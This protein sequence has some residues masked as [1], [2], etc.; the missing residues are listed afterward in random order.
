P[1]KRRTSRA[2]KK[3]DVNDTSSPR[4]S[5]TS[6]TAGSSR[7]TRTKADPA[8]TTRGRKT[9][10]KAFVDGDLNLY[11]ADSL[12]FQPDLKSKE[13]CRAPALSGLVVVGECMYV[14]RDAAPDSVAIENVDFFKT[15]INFVWNSNNYGL[16][17]LDMVAFILT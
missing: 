1:R 7:R 4:T 16:E 11:K 8:P 12:H 17:K 14:H 5:G 10:K 13:V 3:S 9:S 6:A 15:F 2:T